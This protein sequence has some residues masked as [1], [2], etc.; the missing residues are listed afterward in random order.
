MAGTTDFP[1]NRRQ[2]QAHSGDSFGGSA[3]K[4][5]VDTYQ[6]VTDRIIEQLER[7]VAPWRKPWS[8]GLAP[9]NLASGHEY[10]GINVFVLGCCTPYGSPFWVTFKQAK[11]LG[12]SVKKGEKGWPIV[13][14]SWKERDRADGTK[15]RY[16]ILRRFTVFNAQAQCEG[17]E[18]PEIC[19]QDPSW[20]PIEAA[21]EIVSGYKNGPVVE[22]GGFGAVYS[23]INDRVT[24]P[25]EECFESAEEYYCT[26]FHELGHSS[27]HRDRLARE[28]VTNLCSFGSHE[29]GKEELVA[30]MTAAYLC[31]EAG[32]V[33]TTMENSA[34]Y[35]GGWLAK[36]R[37]DKRLVVQAAAQAQKAA[38]WILGQHQ[39]VDD[40]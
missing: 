32:I 28:G 7:G 37:N 33:Q 6:L 21:E 17:I 5:R 8:G 3:V 39:A 9:Q 13:F 35:I 2:N 22:V 10:R 31:G 16:G 30:E 23:P 25:R 11:A 38:D 34:A 15:E 36:L 19:E 12:G 20:D 1:R 4:G 26:L 29:Y 14:W 27:G 18:V 40:E 24:M